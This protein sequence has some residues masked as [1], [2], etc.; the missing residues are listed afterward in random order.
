MATPV[1]TVTGPVSSDDLGK[2]LIQEHFF[3][4][5][6]GYVG[7]SM[8]RPLDEEEIVATGVEVAESL[9]LDVLPS[10]HRKTRKQA[11]PSPLSVPLARG[12]ARRQ[13]GRP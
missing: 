13:V 10:E 3:F 4:G 12:F 7:D 2:T 11:T 5:Y 9:S 8:L 1:N 6:P